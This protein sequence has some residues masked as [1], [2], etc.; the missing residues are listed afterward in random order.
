MNDRPALDSAQPE[1]KPDSMAEKPRSY[2]NHR[3]SNEGSVTGL[4]MKILSSLS[5]DNSRNSKAAEVFQE[6]TNQLR[7]KEPKRKDMNDQPAAA[8][9]VAAVTP[10][11]PPASAPALNQVTAEQDSGA[12]E[13]QS[14]QDKKVEGQLPAG[15]ETTG[16]LTGSGVMAK[17][18]ITAKQKS[19]VSD[20]AAPAAKAGESKGGVG[21]AEAMGSPSLQPRQIRLSGKT[22]ELRENVWVDLAIG[23]EGEYSPIVIR[24]GSS[25]YR[26]LAKE[27]SIYQ[28]VLNRPED[29]LIKSN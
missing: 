13:Q 7:E 16:Q 4:F 20:E 22:F 5:K 19:N 3:A 1:G 29:C 10:T 18:A 17:R 26:E 24:K 11:P 27:L 2:Q 25:E 15:K 23:K 14:A 12:K 21:L 8:P 9:Q 6:E 28:D